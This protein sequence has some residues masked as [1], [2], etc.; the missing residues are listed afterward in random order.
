MVLC[1]VNAISQSCLPEGIYFTYQHKIDDFEIDYPG[2][3]YIEGDVHIRGIN[4]QNLN[5]LSILDTIGGS[6]FF[7]IE[8]NP[9]LV[10]LAGLANL[11]SAAGIIIGE[12]DVLT[13]L[14]IFDG[15][16]A[17]P[18]RLHIYSLPAVTDLTGFNNLASIGEELR[19]YNLDAL[20]SMSGF[21]N[22][23][24]V[25][26]S[27]EIGGNQGLLNLKGLEALTSVGDYVYI[28]MV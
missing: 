12:S 28:E 23:V 15:L 21:E 6:L 8:K 22:L 25:G 4:I 1:R 11:A 20:T 2:C 16:A 3:H 24:S 17:I 7:E 5:G 14:E 26:L 18:L 9:A 19:I 13:G 10:S 27:F